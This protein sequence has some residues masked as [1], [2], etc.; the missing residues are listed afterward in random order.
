LELEATIAILYLFGDTLVLIDERGTCLGLATNRSVNAVERRQFELGVGSADLTVTAVVHPSTYVNKLLFGFD[1][2]S[3]QL[4]NVRRGALLH[5]FQA[6]GSRVRC[7]AQSPALDVIGIGLHD[8][9]IL[10]HNIR[11]DQPVLSFT[12]G[13]PVTTLAFRTDERPWLASG[14]STGQIAL[15]SLEKKSL[16]TLLPRAH[17]AGGD[18]RVSADGVAAHSKA[19]VQRP[20]MSVD[21]D[22]HALLDNKASPHDALEIESGGAGTGVAH[23][24]FLVGEPVLLSN[25]GDNAVKMWLCE[26][27]SARLLRERTGHSAPP[28]VVSFY[29]GGSNGGFG[30][31]R[32]LLTASIDRSVRMFSLIQDQQSVELSQGKLES[33]AKKSGIQLAHLKLPPV[34]ALAA[35]SARERNWDN[36]VTA[37]VGRAEAHLWSYINR[38]L[39]KNSI[40]CTDNKRRGGVDAS[41]ITCVA[42][43]ACGSFA[44]IGSNKGWLDKYN[45]QSGQH[46]GVARR[47]NT[48]RAHSGSISFVVCDP[49]NRHI[50]TGASDG[51]M[52]WWRLSDLR[53]LAEC[54]LDSA[55][56]LGVLHDEGRLLAIACDDLVVRVFDAER[57]R[58]VRRLW[59]DGNADDVDGDSPAATA[60]A[61]GTG[62]GDVPSR[63]AWHDMPTR[64]SS[65]AFSP[66]ARWL[67]VASLDAVRVFDV[68]SGVMIDWF[69][70]VRPVTGV[71][72]S[73]FGDFL[74]TTHANHRAVFLWAN[75]KYFGNVALHR[76][77]A[78]PNF[79]DLPATLSEGALGEDEDEA[80]NA[81]VDAADASAAATAAAEAA[82]N[83]ARRE[84]AAV[85]ADQLSR[86]IVT[87]SDVPRTHW[88]TLAQLDVIKQR[89]KPLEAPKAPEAAPFFLPTLPGLQPKFIVDAPDEQ[90]IDS[91]ASRL[92]DLGKLR[93]RSEFMDLLLKATG[94]ADYD[95]LVVVLGS[96][97][98]SKVDFEIRVLRGAPPS[99]EAALR[100]AVFGRDD[101]AETPCEHCAFLRFMSAQ[102]TTGRDFEVCQA[103]L[104]LFLKIHSAELATNAP[105]LA[106]VRDIER[107]HGQL[108]ARVEQLYFKS[109]CL[110]DFLGGMAQEL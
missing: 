84:R 69:R 58:L 71:A 40:V 70:C 18:A 54:V 52:R 103:W 68:A 38:R 14:D 82:A 26:D 89:N 2:G 90:P 21:G 3:L 43:S 32:E 33:V 77:P 30:A 23:L 12:Q 83:E 8:G 19:P 7:L 29:S 39:G 28:S 5:R 74:A 59:R 36:V 95:R 34:T 91:N 106:L 27:N 46:R 108:W 80:V 49:L 53:L 79:A 99:G 51:S 78:V 44:F 107:A 47:G 48:G 92:L 109:L 6:S 96:L 94:E 56:A 66:D 42:M 88:E 1:D 67:V 50:I 31:G 105:A 24:S 15:W 98:P 22:E 101:G 16:L 62:T 73:P 41:V 11:L 63:L 87:L 93:P 37:H 35:V 57:R 85:F 75:N 13:A 86:G 60:A 20:A 64:I 76:V 55:P 110:I 81:A 100:S 102:L 45:V 10:M 17:G 25:G 97:S 4:W 72:F 104:A 65:L 61:V 9:R